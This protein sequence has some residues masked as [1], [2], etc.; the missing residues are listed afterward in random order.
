MI[1]KPEWLACEVE[2]RGCEVKP[3]VLSLANSRSRARDAGGEI[4]SEET[5][6]LGELDK[7]MS[8]VNRPRVVLDCSQVVEMGE[9]EVRL[10]MSCLERVMKRNGDA[11]LAGVSSRAMET[12][13]C[14]GAE[15]LFRIYETNEAAIRSFES[16]SSIEVVGEGRRGNTHEASAGGGRESQSSFHYTGVRKHGDVNE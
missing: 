15:R 11:R 4:H 6:L 2:H 13:I 9:P 7:W 3:F 14:T 1:L 8:G 16:H 12:L 10:L 5:V